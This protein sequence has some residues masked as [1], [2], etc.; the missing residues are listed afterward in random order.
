MTGMVVVA[1]MLLW[2]VP[3]LIQLVKIH[4]PITL[5]G[6]YVDRVVETTRLHFPHPHFQLP[7][8]IHYYTERSQPLAQLWP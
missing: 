4:A 7:Q 6:E 2:W 1:A 3:V 8:D 5:F